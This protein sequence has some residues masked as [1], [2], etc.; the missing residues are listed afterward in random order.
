MGLGVLEFGDDEEDV[1]VVE[2]EL[3]LCFLSGVN[4]SRGEAD[5]DEE[6]E[7][8]ESLLRI[9][10]RDALAVEQFWQV[11]VSRKV[12]KRNMLAEG[13]LSGMMGRVYICRGTEGVRIWGCTL[14]C[15]YD[16]V[17]DVLSTAR[18]RE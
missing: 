14:R 18:E 8:C 17:F 7:D 15:G 6:E 12:G 3:V 1:E 2:M 9:S 5:D 13:L 11:G 16:V 10:W 4:V